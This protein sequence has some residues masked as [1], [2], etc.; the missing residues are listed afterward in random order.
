MS[1]FTRTLTL[2]VVT[3]FALVPATLL[4]MQVPGE[5]QAVGV[6]RAEFD[7]SNFTLS[8][9]ERAVI[10]RNLDSSCPR[11]S[12][13][14]GSIGAAEPRYQTACKGKLVRSLEKL[15]KRS[16]KLVRRDLSV[17]ARKDYDA[18]YLAWVSARYTACAR[19]R[20]ENLGGALKNNLFAA[21][22]YFELQRRLKWRGIKG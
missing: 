1:K 9:R 8:E 2:P 15:D 3:F 16:F 17:Q 12:D 18:E 10:A 4:A 5:D 19:D 14:A 6:N 20:S 21:C 11:K 22:Q 13:D 7:Y